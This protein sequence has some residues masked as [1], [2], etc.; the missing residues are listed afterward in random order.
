[1]VRIDVLKPIFPSSSPLQLV[2]DNIVKAD[3]GDSFW[4]E[5]RCCVLVNGP[6]RADPR[7][8]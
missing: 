8:S 3:I 5:G 1:M 2:D 6:R 4:I 7:T